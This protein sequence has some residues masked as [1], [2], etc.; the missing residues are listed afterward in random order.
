[1]DL[2]QTKL[3]KDEWE[4]M[5]KRVH[6]NEMEILKLI[7]N[8]YDDLNLRYNNI[9]S[10]LGLMKIENVTD[11]HHHH[12]YMEYFDK[13][14]GKLIKKYQLEKMKKK[15]KKKNILKKK[16]LIRI[17]NIEDKMDKKKVFEF[18]LIKLFE[19]FLKKGDAYH[20]YTVSKLLKL[21][22]FKCNTYLTDFIKLVL[23]SKKMNKTNMFG[24]R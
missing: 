9:I 17:K 5:E 12:F 20:Y 15:K 7:K 14:I 13:K 21:D 4:A 23:Q 8:G 6:E 11:A 16:D 19:K 1:M 24:L 18:I 2:S 22:V 10:L 3:I